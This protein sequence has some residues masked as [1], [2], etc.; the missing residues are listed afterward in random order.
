MNVDIFDVICGKG[1]DGHADAQVR[2][3][4]PDIDNVTYW[5]LACAL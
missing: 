2:A 5:H 3:P 4:D 1:R